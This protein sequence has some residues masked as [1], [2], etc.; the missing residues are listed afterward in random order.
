MVEDVCADLKQW[1]EQLANTLSIYHVHILDLEVGHRDMTEKAGLLETKLKDCQADRDDAMRRFNDMEARWN[2]EKMRK[3]AA[4]LF[5]VKSAEEDPKIYSQAEVD[6]MYDQWRKDQ[7]DPLLEEIKALKKAQRELLAKMQFMK[8]DRSMPIQEE[9]SLL[10]QREI[11][12]LQAALTASSQRTHGELKPLLLRLGES[13]ASGGL[14]IPEI[15]RAIQ[16]IP[17]LEIPESV[18]TGSQVDEPTPVVASGSKD[19]ELF[20]T[21]LKAAGKHVSPDLASLL[22][23]LGQGFTDGS[24]LKRVVQMIQKLPLPV[25]IVLPEKPAMRSTGTNTMTPIA[26][27]TSETVQVEPGSERDFEGE[28]RRLRESL[29]AQVRA[30]Q[31]EAEK[32]RR[33]AEEAIKKLEEETQ[34]LE[35]L[36]AELRRKLKELQ[37]LLEKA[38][39]G[40]QVAELFQQAGLGDFLGGRDVFERLY[41]DAL[42]RMRTQAEVQARL[43]EESSALFMRTLRDLAAHPLA[44]VDSLLTAN[45]YANVIAP[46]QVLR[47]AAPVQ[48]GDATKLMPREEE[49]KRP[50]RPMRFK[51][52]SLLVDHA[53]RPFSAAR[54]EE[55]RKLKRAATMAAPLVP[56]HGIS[57]P[58]GHP[59]HQ[60]HPAHPAHPVHPASRAGGESRSPGNSG[61]SWRPGQ[62]M[63]TSRPL[64]NGANWPG[65]AVEGRTFSRAGSGEEVWHDTSPDRSSLASPVSVSPSGNGNLE[66]KIAASKSLAQSDRSDPLSVPLLVSAIGP[67]PSGQQRSQSQLIPQRSQGSQGSQRAHRAPV[68]SSH[69]L[70]SAG[71]LCADAAR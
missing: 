49:I 40:N 56:G 21:G 51:T 47:F 68:P 31:A 42:R 64:A 23:Q 32:Q 3:R 48:E 71:S 50:M 69:V 37:A 5:G 33:R 14:E 1:L 65:I 2:E 53:D 45:E 11:T 30:A 4:A 38:G 66:A 67:R 8:Q 34:R 55:D 29:E 13:I 43:A 44:A 15:L 58:P 20:Q 35:Q 9:T 41:R 16:A 39:L 17:V 36:I 6:E 54:K 60:A 27:E 61:N 63:I 12:M 7:V 22:V 70:R 59:G 18:E 57:R 26:K 28:L 24:D 46:L 19:T 25:P 52:T 62:N 10:G